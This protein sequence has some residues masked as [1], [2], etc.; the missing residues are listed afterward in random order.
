[1]TC[2]A[3]VPTAI[4]IMLMECGFV[5]LYFSLWMLLIIHKYT[6]FIYHLTRQ[7]NVEFL[8]LS[9]IIHRTGRQIQIVDIA[10]LVTYLD[11]LDWQIL[12]YLNS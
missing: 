9:D 12:R 10:I 7:E 8:Q 11:Q 5:V 4:L 1:M 2:S 6:L 3:D